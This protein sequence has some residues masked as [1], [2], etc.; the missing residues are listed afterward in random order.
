MQST[1]FRVI[2]SV[3]E[4]LAVGNKVWL[5]TV[6][7]TWGSSPRPKGS[8]FALNENG[9]HIGSLSGGCVEED[10]MEKLLHR[11]KQFNSEGK[12]F[13]VEI[14]IYGGDKEQTERFRLP[15]GGQLKIAIEYLS[16]KDQ[17]NY[18]GLLNRIRNNEATVKTLAM[19]SGEAEF[20]NPAVIDEYTRNLIQRETIIL[21]N[22]TLTQIIGPQ[23]E[24]FIIGASEVSFAVAKIALMMDYKITVCDPRDNLPSGWPLADVELIR[25]MPD[26]AIRQHTNLARTAVL[27]LTHDPR[28]DDMGLME[29]L[30]TDAFYIG[31]MGSLKSSQK[32]RDRLAQLDISSENIAKLRAPI[33]LSIGSKTPVEIA[34]SILAEITSVRSKLVKN[35]CN[36][37]TTTAAV[38]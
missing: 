30:T 6:I 20:E 33:G 31:A 3:V 7:A 12:K 17:A 34:V 24:L 13:P 15:C 21:R 22:N 29:A 4:W 2:D 27:A 36:V 8:L 23:F 25:S 9:Q 19:D 16:Q 26:D 28:L 38:N 18:C 1:D 35:I 11:G 10:L 5:C 37:E 32:R 14:Q